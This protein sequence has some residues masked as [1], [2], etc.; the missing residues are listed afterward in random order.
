MRPIAN[1][2]WRDALRILLPFGAIPALVALGAVLFPAQQALL[3]ALGVAAL[4]LLLFATGFEKRQT[5][6]RRLVLAAILTALCVA[7]RFIPLF[8]PVTA[9]TILAGMWLGG[10]T[11][12]LV[13]AMAAL[14]SNFAFGQGPW[15]PFQ[16]L[17]WGMIGLLAGLLHRP[18]KSSR[19]LLCL[20]GVA[21]GA[22]YSLILDV[23]TVMWHQGSF[24]WSA[25]GMAA[26]TALPHTAVYALSNLIFLLLLAGPI[27]KK[28]ERIRDKYGI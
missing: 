12:F 25:Y 22:G 1:K 3:V 27:G 8:K 7:G 20:Y 18:L 21:A 26:I 13:G 28:L 9:I 19:L 2:R 5:G 4:S 17:A 23:W 16:M 11:G 6:S 10:E 15:T 24:Q 14:C